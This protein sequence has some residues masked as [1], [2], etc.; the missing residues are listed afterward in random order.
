MIVLITGHFSNSTEM[1][2]FRGK[3]IYLWLDIPRFAENCEPYSWLLHT[4]VTHAHGHS[5]SVY[6][7]IQHVRLVSRQWWLSTL[8][9]TS[10]VLSFILFSYLHTL[11]P[12]TFTY[13]SGIFFAPLRDSDVKLSMRLLHVH[14]MSMEV[15]WL[16]VTATEWQLISRPK[17]PPAL[18]PS[19]TQLLYLRLEKFQLYESNLDFEN[20]L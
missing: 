11:S 10:A 16:P 15:G 2:K 20:K 8:L 1:L 6:L 13:Q 9:S 4:H 19:P 12:N 5:D 17:M 18:H 3:G 7:M 14:C